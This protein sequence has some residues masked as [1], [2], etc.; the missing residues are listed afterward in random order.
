MLKAFGGHA[1]LWSTDAGFVEIFVYDQ[2]IPGPVA[3]R[4]IANQEVIPV[5]PADQAIVWRS[6]RASGNSAQVID[7]VRS[8][9]KE[10]W[11]KFLDLQIDVLHGVPGWGFVPNWSMGASR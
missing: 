6:F 2:G 4:K 7:F 5:H 8:Q 10:S 3:A 1:E 9:L 11:T